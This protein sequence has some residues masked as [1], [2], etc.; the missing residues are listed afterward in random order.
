MELKLYVEGQSLL[1]IVADL[2]SLEE[3]VEKIKDQLTYEEDY[4]RLTFLIGCIK[5]NLVEDD[6]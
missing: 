1:Q 2:Q 4:D 5:E 3:T 6:K